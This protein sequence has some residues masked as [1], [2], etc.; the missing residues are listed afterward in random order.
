MKIMDFKYTLNKFKKYGGKSNL[1]ALLGLGL[2]G[3]L[4]LLFPILGYNLENVDVILIFS[5]AFSMLIF[6]I[7]IDI[8]IGYKKIKREYESFQGED[9]PIIEHT[10]T[11]LIISSKMI[12]IVLL[13]G[14]IYISNIG[15]LKFYF[16]FSIIIIKLIMEQIKMKYKIIYF[17]LYGYILFQIINKSI[18]IVTIIYLN[19]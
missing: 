3:L 16:L 19:K 18:Y 10:D 9:L 17:I 15:S 8:L 4:A 6:V 14:L 7:G 1:F 2:F 5:I 13:F 12:Y 11:M